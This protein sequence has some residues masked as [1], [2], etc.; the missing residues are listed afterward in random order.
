MQTMKMN[1][2]RRAVAKRKSRFLLKFFIFVVIVGSLSF[3]TYY[4]KK[5]IETKK[6]T[7]TPLSILYDEWNNKNYKVVYDTA[8]QF[9]ETDRFNKTALMFH[10]YSAFYLA[11]ASTDT[12][13]AQSLVDEAINNIRIVLQDAK[14]SAV[15]QLEYMLGKAYFYKNVLSS[16]HYYSDLAIE[17]LLAS[18]NYGYEADDIPEY[19]GLSYSALGRIQE[20]ISAF[21]EALSVRESDVLL[22][23][24][25]EQ[26]YKSGQPKTA[27]QYLFRVNSV[28]QN[29]ELILRSKTLLGQIYIDDEKY[30]EA[31]EIFEAIIE[32]EPNSADAYY[33]LGVT[34]EKEGDLVKARAE[35]R[36]AL[37]IQ[38]NHAGALNKM[39]SYK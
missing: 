37:R 32:K 12:S 14:P 5:T 13:N 24:I 36:K 29:E 30:A 26:Y 11:V 33:G 35:W 34:Y 8:S 39:N 7:S 31:R 10:G 23:S 28:S 6:R 21:T 15:P 17:H 16:Y 2:S 25:A 20:S 1:A 9:M 38:V 18:K 19:L 3:A 22:M 27:V 4:L